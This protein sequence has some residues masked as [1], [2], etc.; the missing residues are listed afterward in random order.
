M[1]QWQS[2]GTAAAPKATLHASPAILHAKANVGTYLPTKPWLRLTVLRRES[3]L[4]RP[5]L[6]VYPRKI[7][8]LPR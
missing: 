8:L 4:R 1:D 3:L 6:V 5:T 7:H 2:A